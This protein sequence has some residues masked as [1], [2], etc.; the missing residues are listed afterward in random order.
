[1]RDEK[2]YSLPESPPITLDDRWFAVRRWCAHAAQAAGLRGLMAVFACMPI[3]DASA[4]GGAIGRFIGPR[5]GASRKALRNLRRA[6][7][8]NSDAENQRILNGMW[9]NLGRSIAEYPHLAQ[10]SAAAEGRV[11]VIN[12]EALT[13]L[14]AGGLPSIIFGGHLSNWEIGPSAVHLLLGRSLMSV[15]RA[16]NN[17][18]V[19]KLLRQFHGG[20]RS[21]PKGATGSR[22]LIRHLRDG[23]SVA[24]LADQ[25][26]N[27]GISVP[28]FGQAAMT[29]PAIARLA[30]RFHYPL[31]PVLVERL[32]GAHFRCTILAPVT[33]VETGDSVR[34]VLAT[35]TQVNVLL[36]A[37]V[38]ARPEQWLWVHSRWPN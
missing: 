16:A 19:D 22:E 4:C 31:V 14:A 1:M 32:D 7:P 8:E 17:P 24:M 30:Y 25:K 21:V 11:E 3:D 37:W 15:Y 20:R 18:L 27:D 29:A 35:M 36:E 28:F 38:R 6:M 12:G 5:L 34:D 9:D 33:L 26:Q 10:I 23:G 2:D 13:G